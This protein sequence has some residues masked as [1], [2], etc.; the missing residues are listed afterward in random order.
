MYALNHSLGNSA[1]AVIGSDHYTTMQPVSVGRCVA[2]SGGLCKQSPWLIQNIEVV[3]GL[4]MVTLHKK[5]SG[6]CRFI[7]GNTQG[8]RNMA[9]LDELRKLRTQSTV[10]AC[11]DGDLFQTAPSNRR[12]KRAQ[13]AEWKSGESPSKVRITLPA[14][15]DL[16]AK[17]I[18][19][20]SSF[21]ITTNVS[22]E[23]DADVLQHIATC[24]KAS[25]SQGRTRTRPSDKGVRWMANR[26]GW[27]ATRRTNDKNHMKLFRPDCDESDDEIAKD[28]A[29]TSA[30]AWAASEDVDGS[31][32]GDDDDDAHDGDEEQNN[33][34]ASA[35]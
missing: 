3:E 21:D 31:G 28:K 8:I 6:F 5:D 2:V 25:E 1:R 27:L 14:V 17:E 11:S 13:L 12:A 35:A 22:V 33:R 26:G 4:E 20:K 29:K 34:A 18:H 16:P 32:S 19:V 7:S 24:M 10:D 9:F 30:I 15:G 23:I